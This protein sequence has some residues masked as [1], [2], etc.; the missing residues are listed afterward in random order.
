MEWVRSQSGVTQGVVD[1]AVATD[2]HRCAVQWPR[3]CGGHGHDRATDRGRP[4]HRSVARLLIPVLLDKL[5]S[6]LLFFK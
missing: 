1:I 6:S 4:L 5:E 3:R 2:G